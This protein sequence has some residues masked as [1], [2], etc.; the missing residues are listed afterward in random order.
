M[1][2]ICK[3][4]MLIP[5]TIMFT[6]ILFVK[7]SRRAPG[8]WGGVGVEVEPRASQL[9]EGHSPQ[10]ASHWSLGAA[11]PVPFSK[12]GSTF[13]VPG[14]C[15]RASVQMGGM[16]A[17]AWPEGGM[18]TG[19]AS[20]RGPKSLV[21]C[22]SLGRSANATGFQRCGMGLALAPSCWGGRGGEARGMPVGP[23]LWGW[24]LGSAVTP[25]LGMGGWGTQRK[26]MSSEA[27]VVEPRG[28]RADRPGF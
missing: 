3:L 26:R 20:V 18:G 25:S 11:C 27:P 12:G 15:T 5:G 9:G 28:S 24:G 17:G 2:K 8:R 14:V 19:N 6:G 1:R 21:G 7:L 4:E 13:I 10:P 22:E 23:S 16:W